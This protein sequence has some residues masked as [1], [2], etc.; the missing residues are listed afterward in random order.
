MHQADGTGPQ[1][2]DRVTQANLRVLLA[3]DAA[4]QWLTEC[5]GF[6][7]HGLGHLEHIARCQGDGGY[8]DELC[9]SA[10]KF[11]AH[12]LAVLADVFKTGLAVR[13]SPAGHHRVHANTVARDKVAHTL[14]RLHN[15]AGKLMSDNGRKANTFCFLSRENPQ[16]SATDR[17]RSDRQN[18][19][20]R[21]CLRRGDI[22]H[23]Q[24]AG[25]SQ[26]S[27]FHCAPA[28]TSAS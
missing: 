25:S 17:S 11:V 7:A 3:V 9:K 4:C 5:S 6:K 19:L 28:A 22:A 8:P 14:T 26:Y 10:V 21:S 18:E 23:L 15:Y 20:T 16:V 27:R 24:H 13:A 1:N 2:D 12:G